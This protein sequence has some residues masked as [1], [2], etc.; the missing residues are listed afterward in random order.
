MNYNTYYM[1][2]YLYNMNSQYKR[3]NNILKIMYGYMTPQQMI[4][5]ECKD[6]MMKKILFG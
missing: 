3:A 5:E 4:N 1:I 6:E 2:K